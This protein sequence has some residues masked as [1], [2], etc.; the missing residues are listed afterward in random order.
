MGLMTARVLKRLDDLENNL[1]AVETKLDS[2]RP[3]ADALD[4]IER[5][6]DEILGDIS[7]LKEA[8]TKM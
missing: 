4:K 5:R 2:V 8:Y 1:K 7:D 3:S 6:L